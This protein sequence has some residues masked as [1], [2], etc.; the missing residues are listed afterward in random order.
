MHGAASCKLLYSVSE[1][2]GFASG[3]TTCRFSSCSQ[4]FTVSIYPVS[5]S[6]APLISRQAAIRI[7]P[8]PMVPRKDEHGWRALNYLF[9]PHR[10]TETGAI[11]KA[12]DCDARAEVT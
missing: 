9:E 2:T 6:G 7:S 11:N 12:L 10:Y 8:L 5:V 4:K 3:I 1:N